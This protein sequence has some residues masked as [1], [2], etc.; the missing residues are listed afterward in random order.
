MRSDCIY[1]GCTVTFAECTVVGR[2]VG[3]TVWRGTAFDQCTNDELNLLHSQFGTQAQTLKCNNGSIIVQGRRVEEG[4]YI[5]EL[6]VTVTSDMIGKTVQCIYYDV[7]REVS[8][9]TLTINYSTGK[10]TVIVYDK[11]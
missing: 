11:Q 6:T 9:G 1:P 7:N 2:S 4:C 8:I 3:T 10:L 5:S